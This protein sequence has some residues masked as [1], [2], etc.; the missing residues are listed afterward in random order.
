[1]VRLS[2]SDERE[3]Q[4]EKESSAVPS[5]NVIGPP[6]LWVRVRY[7]GVRGRY[8]PDPPLLYQNI[9]LNN[10]SVMRRSGRYF[11]IRLRGSSGA[12]KLMS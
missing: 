1:M 4:E 5:S 11:F 12:K 8:V 9:T 2:A 10:E 7:L 6:I 3:I